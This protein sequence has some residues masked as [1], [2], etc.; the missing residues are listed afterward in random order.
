VDLKTICERAMEAGAGIDLADCHY[1]E[2]L[3]SSVIINRPTRYYYF[4]AG[5]VRAERLSRILEIGTNC[6][7]SIMSIYK[8][9]HEEDI[10][11]SRIVTVDIAR[12]NDDGFDKYPGIRRIHG[13]SLDEE[14]IEKAVGSFEGEIDLVYIDS[15]HEYEHTKRNVDVY[16]GRLNPR[17]LV[18][19]DIRQ[20]DEMCKLWG[21]L[22]D[23]FGDSAF[24]ASEIS[25]RSGAGFGI[26]RWRGHL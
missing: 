15:L 7:G 25:R 19:D 24:D 26:I 13:D 8:G 9:L 14:V 17:Y 10:K 11:K 6:G 1:G 12:K 22:E 20:C 3:G 2:T 16:A 23:R 21:E 5:L 18:L 4:L